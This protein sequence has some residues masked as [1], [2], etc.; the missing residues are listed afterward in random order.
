MNEKQQT[1]IQVID[2]GAKVCGSYAAL[3]RAMKWAPESLANAKAGTRGIPAAKII[4]LAEL[5]G[6]EPG[7]LWAL[8]RADRRLLDKAIKRRIT[9]GLIGLAVAVMSLAMNDR[10]EAKIPAKSTTY[11]A[12]TGEGGTRQFI[13]CRG[14]WQWTRAKDSGSS[15]RDG[16]SRLCASRLSAA[17]TSAAQTSTAQRALAAGCL[18]VL[19]SGHPRLDVSAT[20][21]AGQRLRLA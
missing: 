5:V 18:D 6:M 21:W 19:E 11:S 1:L 4:L 13:H 16:R 15:R 17:R 7:E 3:A 14:W 10:S 12:S 8:A 2:E 20:A 9:A